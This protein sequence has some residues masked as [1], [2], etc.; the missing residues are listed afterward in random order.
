M[1]NTNLP[2][3]AAMM[4]HQN[5]GFCH[6]IRNKAAP[7]S[8]DV[9]ALERCSLPIRCKIPPALPS[10]LSASKDTVIPEAKEGKGKGDSFKS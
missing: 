1:E 9:C 10:S 8:S 2:K 7:F 4:A 3:Q 5:Q 6:T